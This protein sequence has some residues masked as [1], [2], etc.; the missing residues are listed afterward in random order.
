MDLPAPRSLA[1]LLADGALL[2]ADVDATW[3][4]TT[5]HITGVEFSGDTVRLHTRSGVRDF[6]GREVARIVDGQWTWTQDPELDI[7]ELTQPQSASDDLLRAARTLHGNVP[8]LLAPFPDG[9]R[10]VAV[11]FRPTPGSVR[12][13][14]TLGLA[15]LAPGLDTRRALLSFAAARDLGLREEENRVEFADGTAV[16]LDGDRAVE[17]SGGLSLRDVRADAHHLA[18]EHQ[19]LLH[20]KFPLARLDLDIAGGRGTLQSRQ[21]SIPVRAVVVATVVGE[22]WTWAWADPHLPPSP[23]AN[24]RRFGLDHG[25]LDLV[26]PHVARQP[27]LVDV[28]KPVL[29][30]W[31]HTLVQLNPETTGVV[32]IDAPDLHLPGPDSATTQRAVEALLAEEVPAGVDKQRAR[33]A[34]AQRRGITLPP[35]R[36]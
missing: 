2:Q 18:A 13:A 28:T 17:V 4:S 14:L 29:G 12:S 21:G 1:D 36:G 8:I 35:Q 6:P 34:Y 23:A 15:G 33:E 24:L 20:G 25:I 10:T 11:D 26:R 30:I 32:L 5:G 3:A 16:T 19:L 31:T 22:Q 7:P 9:T 27:W